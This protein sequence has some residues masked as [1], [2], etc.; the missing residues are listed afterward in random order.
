MNIPF[1]PLGEGRYIKEFVTFSATFIYRFWSYF[2]FI[3]QAFYVAISRLGFYFWKIKRT[4][5]LLLIRRKGLFTS[6]PR[7]TLATVSVGVF[8][9]LVPYGAYTFEENQSPVDP[10]DFVASSSATYASTIIQNPLMSNKESDLPKITEVVKHVVQSGDTLYG[11]AEEYL[12]PVD[13]IAYV[14][15]LSTTALLHPGDELTIPPVE[16]LT[17]TV[18]AGESVASIAEK[19]NIS[20]Q[21]VVDANILAPPFTLFGGDVL[22][23]PGG[24][25]PQVVPEVPRVL[26]QAGSIDVP[27]GLSLESVSSAG[28]YIMPTPGTIT[29]YYHYY[30]TA[31]DISDGCNQPIWASNAGQVVYSGWRL[32]GYGNMV[33]V[34]HPDGRVSQYAH[35]SSTAS[36]TGQIVEQ[37]QII[38]YTGATGIAYGCHLHFVVQ[39]NGRAIDPLSI[40]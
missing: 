29:Q 21:T 35:M 34:I 26:A 25:V 27:G 16:G 19:Y 37:G 24:Q 23:I 32:G 18:K 1:W 31:I 33:E 15:H 17:H 20:P 22:V 4:G 5:V 38:G 3:K 11:L 6:T 30:H 13:A 39:Q 14:N 40:L 36:S 28:G 10:T 12:V 9:T 7:M 2:R 8:L